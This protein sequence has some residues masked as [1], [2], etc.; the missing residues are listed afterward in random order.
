MQSSKTSERQKAIQ[1][2]KKTG[3]PELK[4]PITVTGRATDASGKS[5]AGATISPG[6]D[7]RRRRTLGTAKSGPNGVFA[8][9]TLLPIRRDQDRNPSQGTLQVYGTA[10]GH[11]FAW[12][13]MRS[14][15]PR[16]R[17]VD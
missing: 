9:A 1:P 15:M 7:R 12:H 5:I 6:F 3:P 4:A 17:P 10:P 16:P 2:P 13:G 8:S 11:G 14:Y